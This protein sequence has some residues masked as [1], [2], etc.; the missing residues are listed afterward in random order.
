LSWYGSPYRELVAPFVRPEALESAVPRPPTSGLLA[1]FSKRPAAP[2]PVR[3]LITDVEVG[4]LVQLGEVPR[5]RGELPTLPLP[6][7]LTYRERRD[8]VRADGARELNIAQ[9][10]DRAAHI[11]R[12]GE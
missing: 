6:N 1:R 5:S 2:A 3:P 12:L 11:P 10:E 7:E 8:T 4:L 9:P